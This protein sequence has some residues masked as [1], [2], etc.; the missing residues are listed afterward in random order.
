MRIFV[1][2]SLLKHPKKFQNQYKKWN[3]RKNQNNKWVAGVLSGIGDALGIPATL[4][5][6]IFLVA[7]FG[8]GGISLG[9][10]SGAMVLMYLLCW[11][12]MD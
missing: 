12:M 8:I 3:M 9:I 10:S 5:R 7:F 2:C 6:I 11:A 4:L 1:R